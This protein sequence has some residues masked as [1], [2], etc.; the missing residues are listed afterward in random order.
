MMIIMRSLHKRKDALREIRRVVKQKEAEAF[1]KV[2]ERKW[3]T[4]D[5]TGPDHS[6]TLRLV[7]LLVS[8][9]VHG[10]LSVHR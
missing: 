3:I 6:L 9:I 10:N 1:I 8:R 4:P 2:T 7:W 5:P